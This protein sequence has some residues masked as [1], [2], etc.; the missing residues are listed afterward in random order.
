MVL[1]RTKLTAILI[2]ISLAAVMVFES[3]SAASYSTYLLALTVCW[4]F[5][6]WSGLL[7]ESF[8]WVFLGILGYTVLGCLWSEVF[9][10]RDLL[11]VVTRALLVFTFVIGIAECNAKMNLLPDISRVLL[12]VGGFVVALTLINY[13]VLVPEDGRLRGLGQLDSHNIGALVYSTILILAIDRFRHE[14]HWHW[15]TVSIVVAALC[16]SA[17][18]LSGSRNSWISLIIGLFVLVIAYNTADMRRFLKLLAGAMF[19]LGIV[20]LGLI[21]NDSIASIVFPRGDS[22]RFVIWQSVISD[23]ISSNIFFGHG[24]L[25]D[26]DVV[27]EGIGKFKHAHSLY[28]STFYKGGLLGLT[29]VVLTIAYTVRSLLNNL[30]HPDAKLA[31]GILALALVSYIFDSHQLIDKVGASWLML[32]LPVGTGL[33]FIWKKKEVDS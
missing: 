27:I 18:V 25:T 26:D 19:C 30:R 3:Q 8:F 16:I 23:T 7:K 1:S 28:F 33:S 15:M 22:F 24:T 31:L 12:L 11:S 5:S 14:G 29:L 9:V 2:C 17:I 13:F 32:W 6:A 21:V 10:W 4:G 20:V